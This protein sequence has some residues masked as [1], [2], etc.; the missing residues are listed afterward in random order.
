[1]TTAFGAAGD[2]VEVINPLNI[3]RDMSPT[4][5]E[6]EIATGILD[7]RKIDEDAGINTHTT[8]STPIASGKNFRY[9]KR[10]ASMASRPIR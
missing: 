9:R 10:E 5:D 3:E 1:M 6:S 7:F 2:I 4:F 8:P